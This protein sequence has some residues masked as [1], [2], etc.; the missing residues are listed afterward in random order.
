MNHIGR[1]G[2]A[3]LTLLLVACSQA[4]GA[5]PSP[6]PSPSPAPTSTP[7]PIP[8]VG[9]TGRTFLSTAVTQDGAPF[10]LVQG[11]RIRLVFDNGRLT[12]QA[13]CN[14]MSGDLTVDG[15]RLVV[16]D[17]A[18]TEIGC[19]P[20]LAQQ[21]NWLAQLLGSNPS[22]ALDGNDL[23][24]TS[25]T[26]VVTLLDREIAQ[27]DQGL[28]GPT[29]NLT[30]ITNGD[31]ASSVPGGA[32]AT[33]TFNDDGTFTFNDGCNSGGGKYV[34]DGDQ[35]SFSEVIQTEMACGGA[36]GQVEQAVL[37]VIGSQGAIHFEIDADSLA[38]SAGSAGLQYLASGDAVKPQE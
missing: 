17:L 27:P 24:L 34:V 29:W 19:Q 8:P 32:S 36:A 13:G 14:T 37:A 30:T 15:G 4:P 25:G 6:V 3:S 31:V 33:L 22:F 11:T 23:T 18:T 20:A 38:V 21:D 28:V 5:S 12:A 26:T 7:T 2:L 16:G 1:L 10:A 35:I 9:L